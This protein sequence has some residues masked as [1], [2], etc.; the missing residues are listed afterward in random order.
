[1]AVLEVD[2]GR[3][4]PFGAATAYAMPT[5]DGASALSSTWFCAASANVEEGVSGLSV[6]VANTGDE[7]RTGTVTWMPVGAEPV[8]RSVEVPPHD[9]LALEADDAVDAGAVSAVVELDGGRIRALEIFKD[10]HQR[11]VG[12]EFVNQAGDR[13]EKLRS[14][15]RC[16]RKRRGEQPAAPERRNQAGQFGVGRP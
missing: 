6:L 15:H 1:M 5:A 12:A 4:A 7:A 8:A 16:G 9:A 10:Q 14:L 11:Q 13:G 3:P 2:D